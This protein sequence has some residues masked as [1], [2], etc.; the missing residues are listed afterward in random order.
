MNPSTVLARVIV[1]ELVRCGVTD[2]VLCPGS[3]NAPL[4]FALQAAD[5]AGRLRLHVRIDERTAGFLALGLAARSRRPVPVCTTSGTAVA[6]LHPAVLEA[7][8]SG[9]PLIALTADRPPALVGTG[10]NQTIAQP[11]V[12]AHA[13]RLEAGLG[14]AGDPAEHGRWRSRVDRAVAAATAGPGPVHLNVA[15]AE[16]LVPDAEAGFP[17]GRP[18]GAPWT[19]VAPPSRTAAPL[20]LDPAAP[21]LVIAGAGAPS[22]EV[23]APVVAEPSS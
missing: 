5:A 9:V 3:R 14:P 20:P 18:G 8:F 12:F 10:A 1:D 7:S 16:P 23:A 21:T 19:A 13:V 6:N 2:A 4:S 11:G 22:L 17:E 15:F